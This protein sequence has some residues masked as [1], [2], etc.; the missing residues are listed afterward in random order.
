MIM[1]GAWP[2]DETRPRAWELPVYAVLIVVCL[3]MW[4]L[5]VARGQMSWPC[6]ATAGVFAAALANWVI[7]RR[8]QLRREGTVSVFASRNGIGRGPTG[9]L[10][11]VRR[12]SR[13]RKVNCRRVKS[14]LW[15]I[16][17]GWPWWYLK[18][19]SAVVAYIECSDEE[20]ELL[21]ERLDALAGHISRLRPRSP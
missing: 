18:F 10:P 12:W 13:F 11:K 16:Y 8:K 9:K 3:G 17:V 21:R 15:R 6:V 20:G 1:L 2:A 4:A 19:G 14:G 7:R 5:N